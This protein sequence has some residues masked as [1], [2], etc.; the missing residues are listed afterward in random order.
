MKAFNLCLSFIIIITS[1]VYKFVTHRN[2]KEFHQSNYFLEKKKDTWLHSSFNLIQP[3]QKP[4]RSRE[5]WLVLSLSP[6]LYSFLLLSLL[7]RAV[8]LTGVRIIT[9]SLPSLS[10]GIPTTSITSRAH[11]DKPTFRWREKRGGETRSWGGRRRNK[12][13][14]R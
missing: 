6:P 4:T 13:V 7:P 8:N 5:V 1:L 10:L 12:R 3:E 2:Q 9:A 11:R 14:K